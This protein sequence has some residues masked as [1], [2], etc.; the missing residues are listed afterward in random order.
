MVKATNASTKT[1]RTAKKTV[2]KQTTGRDDAKKKATLAAKTTTTTKK[3]A[4]IPSQAPVLDLSCYFSATQGEQVDA[5]L[6]EKG[7][8]VVRGALTSE[9]LEAAKNGI[10]Q[11]LETFGAD[12]ADLSTWTAKGGR[13]PGGSRGISSKNKAGQCAGAWVV[14]GASRVQQAFAWAQ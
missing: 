1:A 6:R 8:A 11:W 9:E 10:W 5:C 14:R 12:R 2:V 7:I 3:A 4:P 13:W